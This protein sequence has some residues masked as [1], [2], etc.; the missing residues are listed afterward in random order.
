MPIAGWSR[1]Q[2]IRERLG[3]TRPGHLSQKPLGMPVTVSTQ[4][5]A[6]QPKR[7]A[8]VDAQVS[9]PLE[10]NGVEEEQGEQESAPWQ[11]SGKGQPERRC[12]RTGNHGCLQAGKQTCLVGCRHQQQSSH[13]FLPHGFRR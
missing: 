10:T 11:R 13:P 7:L 12:L 1:P 4:P 5:V 2:G 9:G 3:S 6:E 8:R